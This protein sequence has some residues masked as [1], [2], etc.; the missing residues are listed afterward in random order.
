MKTFLVFLLS[1][2]VLYPCEKYIRHKK[3]VSKKYWMRIC[4]KNMK[5][6]KHFDYL[7]KKDYKETCTYVYDKSW[8][9]KKK[10]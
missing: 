6:T 5:T 1:I 7:T 10:K 9:K 8:C 2:S 3:R 4:M